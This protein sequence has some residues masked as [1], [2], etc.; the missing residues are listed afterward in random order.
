[1]GERSKGKSRIWSV[2]RGSQISFGE[3]DVEWEGLALTTPPFGYSNITLYWLV[4]PVVI[5]YVVSYRLESPANYPYSRQK[6]TCAHVHHLQCYLQH[7]FV[8]LFV[9][10]HYLHVFH[11]FLYLM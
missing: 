6:R 2:Q 11:V 4:P 5:L 10:L 9:H 8:H 7:L 3:R 1:M